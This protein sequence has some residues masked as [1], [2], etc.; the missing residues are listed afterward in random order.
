MTARRK[1]L[2]ITPPPRWQASSRK[3]RDS[4][5]LT[6]IED[7]LHLHCLNDP[8]IHPKIRMRSRRCPASHSDHNHRYKLHESMRMSRM[9][10]RYLADNSF[11]GAVVNPQLF[12]AGGDNNEIRKKLIAIFEAPLIAPSDH[13]LRMESNSKKNKKNA[14][15]KKEKKLLK[16]KSTQKQEEE[17]IKKQ[18]KLNFSLDFGSNH[19]S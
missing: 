19:A 7:S 5:Q 8:N 16:R 2:F 1:V 14:K 11:S 13:Q 6:S 3:R 4:L 12:T 18:S 17:T 15:Q 9:R 10:S